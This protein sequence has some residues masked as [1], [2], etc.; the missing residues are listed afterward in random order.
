MPVAP[1]SSCLAF[2]LLPSLL[3][4][5]LLLGF[6]LLSLLFVLLPACFGLLLGLG[7]RCGWHDGF[8][9]FGLPCCCS[10]VVD[11]AVVVRANGEGGAY[12]LA[13]DDDGGL[14]CFARRY[15]LGVRVVGVLDLAEVAALHGFR[16]LFLSLRHPFSI[17]TSS[18]RAAISRSMCALTL[19]WKQGASRH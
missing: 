15:R 18:G 13:V 3:G 5:A 12:T 9:V 4:P 10:G 6:V 16:T 17:W 11:G 19:V 8:G 14:G 2:L 1:R 7:W